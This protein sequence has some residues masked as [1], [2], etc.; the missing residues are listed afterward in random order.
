VRTFD[1]F[2][3]AIPIT[4]FGAAPGVLPAKPET[5]KREPPS[6]LRRANPCIV[7]EEVRLSTTRAPARA[8]TSQPGFICFFDGIVDVAGFGFFFAAAAAASALFAATYAAIVAML[9]I[10]PILLLT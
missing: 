7:L 5:L 1:P 4:P 8:S 9:V 10:A 2:G 3:A 6:L